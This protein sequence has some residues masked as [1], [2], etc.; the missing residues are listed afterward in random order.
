LRGA[1]LSGLDLSRRDLRGA[2]FSEA[3]LTW[4]D[5]QHSD[6][7]GAR[8]V[9]T[10]FDNVRMQHANLEG[11]AIT[12]PI[13]F[14]RIQGAN[15]ARARLDRVVV[16]SP[17]RRAEFN[18]IDVNL[19]GTTVIESRF[20]N[21]VFQRTR[22]RGANLSTVYFSGGTLSETDFAGTTLRDVT[23]DSIGLGGK[24]LQAQDLRGARL[25]NVRFQ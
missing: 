2:D 20:D 11:A 13:G 9:G 25:I 23:F 15:L 22:L 17:G 7:R 24:A 14:P 12:A 6:L 8:F 5:L 18:L 4:V 21:V 19:E 16:P 10:R 1:D 3:L